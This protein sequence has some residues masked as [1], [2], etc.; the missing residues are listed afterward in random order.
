MRGAP[1]RRAVSLCAVLAL[2]AANLV[3]HGHARAAVPFE[4]HDKSITELQQALADHQVTS[5]QLVQAYLERIRAYDRSGPDLNAIVSLNPAA[6]EQADM[7]DAERTVRGPRGPLHGIP[8]LVKDNFGTLDMPT[9]DGTLALATFM[10]N[11]DAA[12]VGRLKAAGAIILGKTAMHELAM[13][14]LTVSSLTGETRNPYD[15]RRSPGGS[16]GGTGASVGAS[17]AAAG[18]GTDTCGSIRVPAAY[19]NLFAMRAT[20]G[21]SSRAGI[22]PLSST[23]DMAGPLTRT[24]TDLAIMMD[25]TV[26]YDPADPSTAVMKHRADPQY[27][28]HLEPGALK[29]ARIG[30]MRDYMTPRQL[31]GVMRDKM[32][33]AL[34]LMEAR[35]AVLVDV[36]VPDLDL[37]LNAASNIVTQEFRADFTEFLRRHP[38]APITSVA[39]LVG[40]G[41]VHA[42]ID[43]RLK[44]R[45][46]SPTRDDKA[47]AEALSKRDEARRMVMDAMARADVDVLVYPTIT[48]PPPIWGAELSGVAT[49][50][51]SAATGLPALAL[52]LGLSSERLPVGLDILGKPFEEMRLLNLAYDWESLA[53]PREAPFSTPPLVHGKAPADFRFSVRLARRPQAGGADISFTYDPVTALLTYDVRISRLGSD[54][55][56]AVTLQRSEDGKPGSII[57]VLSRSGQ[58]AKR[59]RRYLTPRQHEDLVAG[60]LMAGFYTRAWPLGLD[61][62]RLSPPASAGP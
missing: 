14:V 61:R 15:P 17:F 6:L 39:E 12:Q 1:S 30:V 50:G 40:G 20:Y 33:A 18:M 5:R 49:C 53:K 3:L 11:E 42:A 44:R 46:A 36:A 10:T 34:D 24:V 60:R 32:S 4:V 45:S 51:L 35:G 13:N 55:P 7:L 57:A 22:I 56:V 59:G 31:N 8:I 29:G 21:L 2:A 16:S 26:G 19:Q 9:S 23:E 41:L 47:I 27:R 48:Q 38:E 62:V 43:D 37:V 25:A 52:P 54:V 28:V 58:F